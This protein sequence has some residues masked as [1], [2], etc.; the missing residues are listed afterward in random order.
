MTSFIRIFATRV[1]S[2]AAI[3]FQ[4]GKQDLYHRE[5]RQQQILG[6]MKQKLHSYPFVFHF[7]EMTKHCLGLECQ[8]SSKECITLTKKAF[9][10]LLITPHVA[11]VCHWIKVFLKIQCDEIVLNILP[12]GCTIKTFGKPFVLHYCLQSSKTS[13]MS[14]HAFG[15]NIVQHLLKNVSTL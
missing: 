10:S 14:T 8:Q 5:A 13:L 12:R 15:W 2:H 11:A 4:E 1:T 7:N 6:L 3:N 9:V